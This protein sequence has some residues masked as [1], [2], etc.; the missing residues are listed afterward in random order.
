MGEGSTTMRFDSL[1]TQTIFYSRHSDDHC[2]NVR[3]LGWAGLYLDGAWVHVLQYEKGGTVTRLSYT[4][5]AQ[6][7][8]DWQVLCDRYEFDHEPDE[9]DWVISHEGP[10]EYALTPDGSNWDSV[11]DAV[12]HFQYEFLEII[13]VGSPVPKLWF[14]NRRHKYELLDLE[15]F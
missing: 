7:E 6:L 13:A 15:S 8:I 5:W 3:G 11:L 4:N 2:G 14:C 9:D 10:D 12:E 1:V